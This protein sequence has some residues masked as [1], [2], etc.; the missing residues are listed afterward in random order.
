MNGKNILISLLIGASLMLSSCGIGES[1]SSDSSCHLPDIAKDK[2][3]NMIFSDES[4]ESNGASGYSSGT[5]VE[6]TFG[7]SSLLIDGES[8][9]NSCEHE[10]EDGDTYYY[11][12]GQKSYELYIYD[13]MVYRVS[14][15]DIV[16][17]QELS[18]GEFIIDD[19]I[20]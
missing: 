9:A 2:S 14:L 5:Q 7:N 17:S 15:W 4:D 10:S 1:S 16:S 13:N 12:N 19:N 18:L 8:V 6:I 3:V 11:Y 20:N